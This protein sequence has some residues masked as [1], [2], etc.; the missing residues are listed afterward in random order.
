MDP[1]EYEH[2][3]DDP[4]DGWWLMPEYQEEESKEEENTDGQC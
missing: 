4:H 3:N 2:I 1:K